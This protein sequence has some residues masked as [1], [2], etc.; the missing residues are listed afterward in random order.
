MV[1]LRNQWYAA[2]WSYE[3]QEEPLGRKILGEDVAI[4]RTESGKAAAI[5]SVCPHRFA[6]LEYGVVVGENLKC[7]YHGL[8]FGPDGG[9]NVI[10]AGVRSPNMRTTGY[11][12]TERD[13]MI[14]L[15][16]GDDD[17]VVDPPCTLDVGDHYGDTV[18]GHL[19]IDAHYQLVTDNLMDDA[20]ATHL[21]TAFATEGHM[22]APKP[23]VRSEGDAVFA[24]TFIP[25]TTL[26]PAFRAFYDKPGNVDQWLSFKWEVPSSVTIKAGVMPP[27]HP[28][29]E[30]I[31]T[32]ACNIITPETE[33]SSHYFWTFARNCKQDDDALSEM[34]RATLSRVY[35]TEDKWML[36]G[37]QR[38]MGDTSFWDGKP[39]LLPQDKAAIA[40]RRHID[41]LVAAQESS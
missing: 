21:H 38:R 10:P 36:E 29:E 13:S 22:L 14:W 35:H 41:S 23:E 40:I 8:Q 33:T 19:Q 1:F 37:Q 25:D 20:H 39:I 24:D 27:G 32:A 7:K 2:A 34:M 28:R 30:G 12:V 6:P 17:R 18:R 15:W 9:C 11:S 3:V 5:G 26:I 4:Y 16:I 31:S